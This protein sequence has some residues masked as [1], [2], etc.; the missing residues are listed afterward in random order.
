M[1]KPTQKEILLS[2]FRSKKTL[3]N[4]ELRAMNPPMFQFPVRIMELKAEG[5]NIVGHKDPNEP[6][7]Y[8][9]TLYEAVKTDLFDAA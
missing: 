7:K 9:Y 6:K 5:Y 8:Y 1:N 2:M 3:S 4:Y